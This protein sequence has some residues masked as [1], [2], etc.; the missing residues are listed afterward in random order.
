[1]RQ[2]QQWW[3]YGGHWTPGYTALAT[4]AT[5]WPGT[6][7]APPGPGPEHSQLGS[8]PWDNRQHWH[9]DSNRRWD[10][11]DWEQ[12]WY[13]GPQNKIITQQWQASYLIIIN[14]NGITTVANNKWQIDRCVWVEYGGDVKIK[15]VFVT[16]MWL[17]ASA[18]PLTD[19]LTYPLVGSCRDNNVIIMLHLCST[20]VSNI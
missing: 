3:P 18:L 8:D 13:K 12:G 14:I 1:M 6:W 9:R 7:P 4:L 11:G 10:T 2:W 15:K 5:L 19:W 20:I 16:G 17:H